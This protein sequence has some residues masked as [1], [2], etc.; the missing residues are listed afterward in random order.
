MSCAVRGCAPRGGPV[1]FGFLLC[2]L[3]GCAH[4]QGS[5]CRPANACKAIDLMD[6][7][8]AS[9]QCEMIRVNP[10]N[11]GERENITTSCPLNRFAIS[12]SPQSLHLPLAVFASQTASLP[13]LHVKLDAASPVE[14]GLAAVLV[15]GKSDGCTI[16]TDEDDWVI[17]I[18][19][20]VAPTAK[21]AEIRVASAPVVLGI[22]IDLTEKAC[23]QR[24]PVCGK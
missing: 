11:C 5:S 6:W 1:A 14:G 19:C 3:A 9:T 13:V 24:A 18:T 12:S 17:W 20:M 2:A 15:D 4:G 21:K 7:C 23:M 22:S 16:E 8:R 10:E